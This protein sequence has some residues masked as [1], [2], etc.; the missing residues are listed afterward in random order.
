MVREHKDLPTHRDY[1][2]TPRAGT[3]DARNPPISRHIFETLVHTCP[4]PCT[5][6]NP[7]HDCL[8]PPSGHMF[9]QRIPKRTKRSTNDQTSPIWGF[10]AV[11]AVSFAY[12]FVYHCVMV[13]G[14]LAFWVW[15]LKAHPDDWQNAAIPFTVVIGALSLFWSS[16]GIL[17]SRNDD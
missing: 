3:D 5:W 16:S 1:E 6:M 2:Y 12:V 13:A 15:W 9:L 8:I 14:P 17:T 10:E 7:L 4:S 11:F